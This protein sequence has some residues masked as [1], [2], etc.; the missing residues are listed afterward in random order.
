[1]RL[2]K[3]K[4]IEERIAEHRQ[5]LIA[6]PR[7][8]KGKW[9]QVFRN[10]NEIYAELGCGRGQFIL[11]LA[12]QNPA[13]NYIAVE[14]RSSVMLRALEKAA[15][16][17]LDNIVFINEYIHDVHE[18]FDKAELAGIY[19]NFSDPWPKGSHA[20]RRLTHGRFLDG[21]RRILKEGSCIEFK[22]DNDTLFA[23]AKREFEKS[24]MPLLRITEDLHCTDYAAKD[25]TTEYE[26]KFK[27]QGKKIN[28]CMVTVS[29]PVQEKTKAAV[30]QN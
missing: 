1:M 13:R 9:R 12:E 3:I 27:A 7:D 6:D 20:P 29:V 10:G 25:V 30:G 16:A 14:G 15:K 17:K 11:A 28:Y 22:T 21:Y 23:F 26:D 19:L 24:G 8:R 5:C 18:Y 2:R 4:N